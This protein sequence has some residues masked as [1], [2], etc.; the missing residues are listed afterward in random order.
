MNSKR[1]SMR[2]G[3][4]CENKII[5]RLKALPT[6]SRNLLIIERFCFNKFLLFAADPV[7]YDLFARP[8]HSSVNRRV[9][10]CDREIFHSLLFYRW[11]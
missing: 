2:T 5:N 4:E 6:E 3:A 8:I 1:I 10:S 11:L 7:S 9:G